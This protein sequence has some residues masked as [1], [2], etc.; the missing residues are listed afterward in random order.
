M[1]GSKIKVGMEYAISTEARKGIPEERLHLITTSSVKR[2]RV[3]EKGVERYAETAMNQWGEV[4]G[5]HKKD[6][7]KGDQLVKDTGQTLGYDP[8]VYKARDFLMPWDEYK[9]RRKDLDEEAARKK[10]E[11]EERERIDKEKS[12]AALAR[13]R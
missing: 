3:L 13:L 6:G 9:A 1:I 10:A 2:V 11:R 5:A 7:I 8:V 4:A 12:D